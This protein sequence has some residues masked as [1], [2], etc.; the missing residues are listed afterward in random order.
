LVFVPT[1]IPT[2]ALQKLLRAA[3]PN[4]EVT[5]FS[6]FRDFDTGLGSKPDAVLTLQ[7]LLHAKGLASTVV[8]KTRGS[9]VEPYALLAIGRQVAPEKLTSVGAVDLL[10]R[11]GMKELVARLLG[12]APR[13]ERVSKLEDLLPLLQ[14]ETAEAVLL[15]ARLVE[16]FRSRSKLDLR[17]STVRTGVGLPALSALSSSGSALAANIKALSPAISQQM[18]VELWE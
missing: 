7:P 9:A 4:A 15:P 6:R 16:P 1:D 12:S 10:G 5:V 14:F 18:G 17:A 3:I 8:G 13:V 11:Q 2:H